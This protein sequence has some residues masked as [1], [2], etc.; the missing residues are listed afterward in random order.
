V[1]EKSEAV[2]YD[3]PMLRTVRRL[4]VAAVVAI[5]LATAGCSESGG[6]LTEG[7]TI[8]GDHCSSCHGATGNGGVGP[9]LHTVTE[10][11]PSCADHIEWVTLGSDGWEAA[12]GSTYGATSRPVTGGMPSHASL[13]QRDEITE[14]AAFERIQ[15]GGADRDAVLAD[16]GLEAG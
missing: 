3:H 4:L 7:R 12:H 13:L 8:Y 6:A 9:S 2:S 15:F 1:P 10:T 16:C 14:V 5:A 11:W